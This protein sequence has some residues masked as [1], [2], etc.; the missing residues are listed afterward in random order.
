[1]NS[2]RN[3]LD[4][5]TGVR[6]FAAMQVVLF[7][8]G[9]GYAH[10]HG[11][12]G[13]LIS[14]LSSGWC[15]VSLFFVLSGFV[16][17]YSY[18]GKI[19]NAGSAKRFWQARFARIYPVYALSLLFCFE[20]I[21]LL[22]PGSI[23][24]VLAMVQSWNP[25][26]PQYGGMWNMPTWTLSVE[27]FFYLLFPLIIPFV[28]R[29]S[30][31]WLW[32]LFSASVLIVLTTGSA[33]EHPLPFV[34]HLPIPL[35][36]LRFPE[37]IVGMSIGLL[38]HR[39]VRLRYTSLLAAACILAII[40]ID[41]SASNTLQHFMILPFAFLIFALAHGTGHIAKF[42][43]TP[44]FVLLGGA[45]YAVYLLQEPI[46][47]WLQTWIGTR[48]HTLDKLIFLPTLLIISVL[49]FRYFEQPVRARL[50]PKKKDPAA[51]PVPAGKVSLAE[52]QD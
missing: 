17:A 31:R 16:L 46:H 37:F 48:F 3:S 28:E 14:F 41:T 12:S 18:S 11:A 39:G 50:R 49:V 20:T 44:L 15:A 45:S 22:S 34:Q 35:M 32:G 13:P 51:V 43:S 6:F 30:N 52:S 25:F 21:H 40:S 9:A 42:L 4:A 38:F 8:F 47:F 33:T 1:M 10:R 36:V 2:Q 23:A 5:L 7:H 29:L 27:A 24:A 19:R 26:H